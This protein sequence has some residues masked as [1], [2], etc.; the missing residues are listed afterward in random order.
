[1]K[2][3][4][5]KVVFILGPTTVGKTAFAR[6]IAKKFAGELVSADSVQIFRGLDIGS[7]KDKN[8][9]V[10][11]H[12]IDI[13]DPDES[14]SV[15]DFVQYTKKKINEISLRAHLP[16]VVGGTG[17]YVKSLTMGFDFGGVDKDE[18]LRLELDALA[19]EKGLDA[20]FEMLKSLDS[21]MA[22]KTD[23]S[24][25]VRLVR[26][27]EIAKNRGKKGQNEVEFDFLVIA[28]VMPREKLYARINA[29]VD[30]MM[31]NGLLEEV[32]KL[33]KAGL[34]GKNQSMHAIGYKEILDFLDG[35]ISLERAVELVKQHTRNYAKRQMTFLRSMQNVVSVDVCSSDAQKT[36]ENLVEEFLKK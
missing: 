8:L 33:Q 11:Q 7:A 10:V 13:L 19:K 3:K 24:N 29:R 15:F 12:G 20:L 31:K 18:N 36:V 26:A 22:E 2:N 32:E 25:A 4:K 34:S 28:L 35:K 5:N 23:R 14:F 27:I 9:D 21:E 16:I 30:E 17:L 6:T 1:M